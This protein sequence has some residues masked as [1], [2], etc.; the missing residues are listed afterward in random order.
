MSKVQPVRLEAVGLQMTR[1]QKLPFFL[2]PLQV[3]S[4]E[5]E[6]LWLWT[7]IKL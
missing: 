5:L 3:C 4:L 7:E 6:D 1:K 2:S